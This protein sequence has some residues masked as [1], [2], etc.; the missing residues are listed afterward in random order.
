M[1]ASVARACSRQSNLPL[2]PPQPQ[3]VLRQVARC[4]PGP[5]TLNVTC[6]CMHV[7]TRFGV[8]DVAE[9]HAAPNLDCGRVVSEAGAG[10]SVLR[11]AG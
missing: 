2:T 6:A 7:P 10:S 9:A 3:Q 1:V 11:S 4:P 8:A 5:T